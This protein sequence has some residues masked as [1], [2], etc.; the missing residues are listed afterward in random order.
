MQT[1]DTHTV[2]SEQRPERDQVS[3]RLEKSVPGRGKSTGEDPMLRVILEC[4]CNSSQPLWL[5]L[6]EHGVGEIR[7]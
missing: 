5:P 1:G 2:T 6:I 3:G 7:R 4:L